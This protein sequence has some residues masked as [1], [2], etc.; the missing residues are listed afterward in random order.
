VTPEEALFFYD[1][2]DE[3][4]IVILPTEAIEYMATPAFNAD[5]EA[6]ETALEK[7][8]AMEQQIAEIHL[9]TI[10]DRLKSDP[11]FREDFLSTFEERIKNEPD[12]YLKGRL[13][14]LHE[15]VV[16]GEELE[17]SGIKTICGPFF[18]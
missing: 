12:R 16:A 4:E 10:V 15:A 3:K 1:G 6:F 9:G 14:E 17:G 13:Q 7:M 8:V 5:C 11:E 18:L 2:R